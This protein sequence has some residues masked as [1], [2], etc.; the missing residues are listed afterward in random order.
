MFQGANTQQMTGTLFLFTYTYP[1]GTAEP[2]LE[3]EIG[4]LSAAWER[5]VVIPARLAGAQRPVPENVEVE[6]GF[7]HRLAG[8]S[9]A[10]DLIRILG[11]YEF[12]EE[13][14]RRPAVLLSRG[15]LRRLA[16]QIK[17]ARTADLWIE[18]HL[19]RHGVE[20]RELL[21]Y[22]YWM[23]L[24]GLGL[25][26]LKRSRPEITF[27]CRA[28]RYDLYADQ[29]EPPY[30]PLQRETIERA[31]AIFTISE[32]GR[33]YLR[34]E[35]P[36]VR[37]RIEVA[38]LGVADP[39]PM[40]RRSSDGRWRVL[41]CSAL[42]PVKRVELLVH[43]LSELGKR[44]PDRGIEWNHL[45]DGPLRPRIEAEATV[46]L[47]SNVKWTI[48]GQVR[49]TDVLNYYRSH[50][51]D[52]FVNVSES[53]GIPVSIMEAQSFGVP[54]V[55][56]AVGG[57]PEIVNSGNGVLL[58]VLPEPTAISDAMEGI[59]LGS[60]DADLRQGSRDSWRLHYQAEAN[61]SSFV[62]RLK[63]IQAERRQGEPLLTAGNGKIQ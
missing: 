22:S 55:A 42:S 30:L 19:R 5:I 23:S 6:A 17:L 49:N 36:G 24:A 37:S 31:D 18:D 59:C 32:H 62:R 43:A 28:H 16:G 50:P 11:A 7:A 2:F 44:H 57:V 56:T 1:Y 61:Y 21:C 4:Y 20:E 53:E 33:S 13:V 8:R 15:H 10:I 52:V 14:F 60:G 25:A 54:A 9:G 41:S 58:P 27:V 40:N 63:E 3:T 26:R 35:H 46:T 29:H 38:R 12:R 39:G 47:P 45:G 34:K 51:V 48:H